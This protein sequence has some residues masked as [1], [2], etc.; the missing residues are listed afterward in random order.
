MLLCSSSRDVPAWG[1]RNKDSLLRAASE[2]G[3]PASATRR[4]SC[5]HPDQS[6]SLAH[7]ALK[8]D[9]LCVGTS[10]PILPFFLGG[11]VALHECLGCVFGRWD[12]RLATGERQAPELPDPFAPLPVC[13]PGMLTGDDGLPLN[14]TPTGYPLEINREGILVD[15]P[16]HSEDIVRRV[17]DVFKVIWQEKAEVIEQEACQILGLKDL[18]EYFRRP[19]NGGFW[20]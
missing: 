18:R 1:G 7:K 15:D 4:G 17:R 20:M 3:L 11:G 8:S 9:D 5:T 12:V 2:K 10:S 6:W 19:G 13:S 16:D 14:E